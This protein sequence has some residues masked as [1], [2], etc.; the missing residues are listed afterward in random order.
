MIGNLYLPFEIWTWLRQSDREQ[1]ESKLA[2]LVQGMTCI[3]QVIAIVHFRN[4]LHW[5]L[6]VVDVKEQRLFF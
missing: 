4:H 6:L 2:G 3:D 1:I 5:G